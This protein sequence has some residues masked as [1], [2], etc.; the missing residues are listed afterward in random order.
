MTDE[1]ISGLVTATL[2]V[3]LLGCAVVDWWNWRRGR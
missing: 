2:V 3:Y 1:M